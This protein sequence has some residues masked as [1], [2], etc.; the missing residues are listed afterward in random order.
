MRSRRSRRTK[1]A[2][3]AA[4]SSWC[5]TINRK[6]RP[7]QGERPFHIGEVASLRTGG[8][9]RRVVSPPHLPPRR[10]RGGGNC[11]VRRQTEEL[12]LTHRA[13]PPGP[14]GRGGQP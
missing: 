7:P 14:Q 10:A 2:S 1:P 4:F 6:G 13:R 11:V 12:P 5:G 3:R 8:D 9:L